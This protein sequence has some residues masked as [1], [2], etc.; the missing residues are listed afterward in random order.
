MGAVA[1][2]PASHRQAV[3][4]FV[5]KEYATAVS[6]PEVA[7]QAGQCA[8]DAAH[9]VLVNWPGIRAVYGEGGESL[10]DRTSTGPIWIG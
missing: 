3:H 8:S 7:V 5:R 1:L 6:L 9:D 10:S 2:H 4:G